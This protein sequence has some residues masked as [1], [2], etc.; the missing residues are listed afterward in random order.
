MLQ[1]AHNFEAFILNYLMAAAN[2]ADP[3]TESKR[4]QRDP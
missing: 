2:A 3:K 4:R 1:I